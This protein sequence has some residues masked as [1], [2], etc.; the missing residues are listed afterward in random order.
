MTL[1]IKGHDSAPI[2]GVA[3][4][5]AIVARLDRAIHYAAA[6]RLITR[7]LW[8]TGSSAPSAQLRTRRMMTVVVG[9]PLSPTHHY[10]P[11][12]PPRAEPLPHMLRRWRHDPHWLLFFEIGI[13]ISRECRCRIGSPKRG[14]LP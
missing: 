9:M 12:H 3:A 14:P 4:K 6:S 8:N 5:S 13:T 1:A 10:S 11:F 7:C 2:D